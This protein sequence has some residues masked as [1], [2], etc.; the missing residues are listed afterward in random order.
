MRKCSLPPELAALSDEQLAQLHHRLDRFT[1]DKT[2][3]LF[4]QTHGVII[5][6][7]K[8]CRYNQRRLKARFLCT[9]GQPALTPADLV[10]IHNGTSIPDERSNSQLLQRRVLDLVHGVKS[11]YELRE[12]HQVAT[13]EQRRALAGRQ[14]ELERRRAENR[15]RRA[16][17]RER[18]LALR[19]L[20]VAEGT[21]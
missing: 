4:F 1:Y 18:E 6:I 13:Y 15:S 7:V 10:A 21:P 8:L 16:N 14:L 20:R 11:A 12:L 17:L 19:A 2:Q 9:A 3:E 5:G